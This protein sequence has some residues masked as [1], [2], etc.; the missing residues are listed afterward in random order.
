MPNDYTRFFFSAHS[1]NSRPVACNCEGPVQHIDVSASYD[2]GDKGI[3]YLPVNSAPNQSIIIP[4]SELKSNVKKP[5]TKLNHTPNLGLQLHGKYADLSM[6]NI[7]KNRTKKHEESN[8]NLQSTPAKPLYIDIKISKMGTSPTF[9]SEAKAAT[10]YQGNDKHLKECLDI[11]TVLHSRDNNTIS[12]L[13]ENWGADKFDK[14]TNLSD[15]DLLKESNEKCALANDV[16]KQSKSE[17][18]HSLPTKSGSTLQVKNNVNQHSYT[19]ISSLLPDLSVQIASTSIGNFIKI[20]NI[21]TSTSVVTNEE[22]MSSNDQKRNTFKIVREELP[23]VEWS[24]R[25]EPNGTETFEGNLENVTI[26]SSSTSPTDDASTMTSLFM[27]NEN[28]SISSTEIDGILRIISNGSEIYT[29]SS[30]NKTSTD[31]LIDMTTGLP[32]NHYH[33]NP[34][35]KESNNMY[36]YHS[37]YDINKKTLQQMK[38]NEIGNNMTTI[39]RTTVTNC[40][41]CNDLAVTK[42]TFTPTLS[43]NLVSDTKFLDIVG[44]VATDALFVVAASTTPFAIPLFTG[45]KSSKDND[46]YGVTTPY[47]YETTTEESVA[48]F[49]D[50]SKSITSEPELV[51]DAWITGR[52]YFNYRNQNIPARFIQYPAGHVSISIDAITLCDKLNLAS[53]GSILIGV[54]C[55]CIQSKTC[56]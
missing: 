1:V 22:N 11:H 24:S 27:T 43:R 54:M 33:R 6:L 56:A 35:L 21:G 40:D 31:E 53:N 19:K 32:I 13:K 52:I 55:K 34:I 2:V 20:N 8:E 12:Q 15:T 14:Y 28:N 42:K 3:Y 50:N 41:K 9:S 37:I 25:V 48:L 36:E 16:I 10:M 45:A 7:D 5:A 23:L 17:I 51:K 29:A 49:R 18:K 44:A 26:V 4:L 46:I 38:S 39:Q 47:S 30:V